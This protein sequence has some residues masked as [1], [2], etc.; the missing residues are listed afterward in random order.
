MGTLIYSMITSVDGYVSDS[1]GNFGWGAP[2][3]ESHVF[4][5]ELMRSTGTYL[6]GRRMYETMVFWET[7]HL[8]PDAPPY[9]VDCARIWQAAD[10]IVYSTTLEQVSSE[11]TRIERSFDPELV[12]KLKAETELNLTVDGPV[13]AA[14]AIRAGLV[15][16]YQLLLGPAIVGGGHRFF[17]DDIRVDL[18]LLDQRHFANGVVYLRYGVKNPA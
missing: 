1:E 8:L 4:M 16:E 5:N 3:E 12:R 6:V 14:Q 2:D 10:K 13:L 17:P 18:E 15:D 9:I 11:R 7:A